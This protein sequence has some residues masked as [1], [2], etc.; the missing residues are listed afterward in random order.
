MSFFNFPWIKLKKN[1][2]TMHNSFFQND[3]AVVMLWK[4]YSLGVCSKI[5][6]QFISLGYL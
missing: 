3:H 6:L 5:Q 1:V 4:L 2:P